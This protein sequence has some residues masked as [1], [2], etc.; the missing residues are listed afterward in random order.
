MRVK[1][2]QKVGIWL[3]MVLPENPPNSTSTDPPTGHHLGYRLELVT[4]NS[5]NGL[6]CLEQQVNSQSQQEKNISLRLLL[7][8]LKV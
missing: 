2:K 5:E 3:V 7:F 8:C 6:D 4:T 1:V